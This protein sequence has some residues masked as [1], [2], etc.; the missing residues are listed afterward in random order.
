MAMHGPGVAHKLR[1]GVEGCH[2][3]VAA[4]LLAQ[5]V[6]DCVGFEVEIVDV[7]VAISSLLCSSFGVENIHNTHC[8]TQQANS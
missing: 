8:D 1:C 6:G 3:D 5:P 4:P 2:A 7:A